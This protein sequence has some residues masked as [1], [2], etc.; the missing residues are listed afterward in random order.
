MIES[1]VAIGSG[2]LEL[3]EGD[4][5]A[6]SGAGEDKKEGN[7]E[8]GAS[9]GSPS[10]VRRRESSRQEKEILEGESS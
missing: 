7:G 3:A 6:N 2:G 8:E 10:E 9:G 4:A 5:A 1:A